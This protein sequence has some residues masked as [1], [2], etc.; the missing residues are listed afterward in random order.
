L[1]KN[2]GLKA[3][4]FVAIYQGALTINRGIETLLAMAPKLNGSRIHLVFMGY[5]MLEPQVMEGAGD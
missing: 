1:R 4:D 3:D 5:G 2:L